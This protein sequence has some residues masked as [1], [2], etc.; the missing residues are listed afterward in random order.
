MKSG[1]NKKNIVSITV[2]VILALLAWGV[3]KCQNSREQYYDRTVTTEKSDWRHHRLIY[4]AHAKCRMECRNISEDEVEFVLNT[5]I[6]NEEKSKEQNAEAPGHCPT[7]ALEANT[8]DGQHV[9]VVFAAC[10]KTTRVITA[11]D[12]DVEHVCHCK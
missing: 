5:G 10:E 9:R 8:K 6:V 2:L 4:T 1:K 3:K 11:I 12:I 7:Y